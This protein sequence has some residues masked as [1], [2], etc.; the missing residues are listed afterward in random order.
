MEGMLANTKRVLI[1]VGIEDRY[2]DSNTL[3]KRGRS[4]IHKGHESSAEL[5]NNGQAYVPVAPL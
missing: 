3:A 1:L 5:F 4:G 2:G